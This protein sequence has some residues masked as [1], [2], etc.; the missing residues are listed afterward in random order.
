M[1]DVIIDRDTCQGR[2]H[3]YGPM[4]RAWFTGTPRRVCGQCGMASLDPADDLDN[5]T[6]EVAT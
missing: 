6:C 3:E 4:E 5:E 1:Y 2:G